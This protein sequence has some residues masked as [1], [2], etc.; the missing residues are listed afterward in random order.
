MIRFRPYIKIFI[1]FI[2]TSIFFSIGI[3][4]IFY[5][6]LDKYNDTRL[7]PIQISKLEIDSTKNYHLVFLGD[8]H[9]QYWIHNNKNSL[10]LGTTGQTSE[11][12]KL[13][14]QILSNEIKNGEKLV[15][16]IGANDVK[17]ITTN[18]ETKN[19][20]INNC[21][22]NINFIISQNKLKFK[23][24]YLMTIPPDFKVSFPY[25]LIN[26]QDTFESKLKI[27]QGIRN[28]AKKN[29]IH[30]IDVYEIFKNKNSKE[31]SSD[32]VHMNNEAYKI[33]NKY[34]E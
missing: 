6:A 8:S 22:T 11:Q 3:I 16:S 34:I 21:L 12:I 30:L 19:Q 2:I 14:Y 1:T 7:D 33:L 25:N 5:K 13:K 26:Y 32:G 17:S 18:P 29:N 15:V 24:I 4:Y 9:V 28:L 27:N 10:N 31:Y 20:I 23:D